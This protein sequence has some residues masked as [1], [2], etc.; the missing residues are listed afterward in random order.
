MFNKKYNDDGIPTYCSSTRSV[1]REIRKT[2]RR[3]ILRL[4]TS[5]SDRNIID[6]STNIV[7]DILADDVPVEPSWIVVMTCSPVE[8]KCSPTTHVVLFI[9]VPSGMKPSCRIRWFHK[10]KSGPLGSCR[11]LARPRQ[12]RV[13]L[14]LSL[15]SLM[16]SFVGIKCINHYGPIVME[17]YYFPFPVHTTTTQLLYFVS[18]RF[19][20]TC[21]PFL[22]LFD[23][24]ES[25]FRRTA[26]HNLSLR[27]E[28]LRTDNRTSASTGGGRGTG[29]DLALLTRL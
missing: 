14:L 15:Q 21:L 18:W 24:D 13:I 11:R 28:L 27:S 22:R 10:E 9:T 7:R 16:R 12:T 2:Q 23:S 25:N 8:F 19:A 3:S 20:R 1:V 6:I 26:R 5:R 29:R 17:M 4:T